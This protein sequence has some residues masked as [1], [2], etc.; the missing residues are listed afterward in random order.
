MGEFIKPGPFKAGGV[1][2]ALIM[3]HNDGSPESIVAI[4]A[5][6]ADTK[7][8][9]EIAALDQVNNK[10]S[11]VE[12]DAVQQSQKNPQDLKAAYFS[13]I[14]A[15]LDFYFHIV[16]TKLYEEK[17]PSPQSGKVTDQTGKAQKRKVFGLREGVDVFCYGSPH[18]GVGLGL[19]QLPKQFS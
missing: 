17:S 6:R 2:D 11:P 5:W 8:A 9:A 4:N 16:Q 15:Y 3:P 19:G 14:K 18:V 12:N 7:Q 1:A 13:H 10:P